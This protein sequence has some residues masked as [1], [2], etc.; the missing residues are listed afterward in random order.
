MKRSSKSQLAEPAASSCD[1]IDHRANTN[2]VRPLQLSENEGMLQNNWKTISGLFVRVV[3]AAKTTF[4][5][6]N[7]EQHTVKRRYQSSQSA[8]PLPIHMVLLSPS[9]TCVHSAS[10]IWKHCY[11]TANLG[12]KNL[13]I[14]PFWE[15]NTPGLNT[16]NL[17][18]VALT[19]PL[20]IRINLVSR[21][22][23]WESFSKVVWLV[24]FN[25]KYWLLPANLKQLV[26][27]IG[28]ILTSC[29]LL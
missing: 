19:V 17:D 10:S 6:F 18:V 3:D 22:K 25:Q 21:W 7:M 26:Q 15:L 27:K 2:H 24:F 23:S 28:K 13:T 1:N 8:L 16:L 11:Y 12:H 20:T 5:A 29:A 14:P 9:R 4:I